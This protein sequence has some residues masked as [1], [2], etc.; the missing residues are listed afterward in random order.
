MAFPTDDGV[1]ISRHF[2]RA[3][4]LLIAELGST[5]R[6]LTILEQR[7]HRLARTLKNEGVEEITCRNMGAG[8][9]KWLG[10]FGIKVIYTDKTEID[11]VIRDTATAS[12]PLLPPESGDKKA[13][14]CKQL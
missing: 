5:W 3:K 10:E 9:F 4:Y 2:G 8:M 7:G 14:D 12:L 11:S 13:Y 6:K 1:T